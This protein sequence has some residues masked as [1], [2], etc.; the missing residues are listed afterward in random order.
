MLESLKILVAIA[1]FLVALRHFRKSQV[2]LAM[3]FLFFLLFVRMLLAAFHSI[4]FSPV[5]G[6][7]SLIS[8]SS[9]LSVGLCFLV[10]PL[11]KPANKSLY[12]LPRAF[13]FIYAF[14]AL[15]FFS[16]ALNGELKA[17]LPSLLKWVYLLQLIMLFG[18]VLEL[19]GLKKTVQTLLIIYAFPA[20]MLLFSIFLGVS[21]RSELDG[22]T[23]F[24]GG[25][26]HEAVYSTL[27]LTAAFY[28]LVYA[29]VYANRRN[30]SV[31]VIGVIGFFAF[32][33]INYRT[34]MIAFLVMMMALCFGLIKQAK[35]LPRSF[36]TILI[37]LGALGLSVID[38]S[39]LDLGEARERFADLPSVVSN[40]AE[41]MTYPENYSRDERRLFSGRL[42]IW[43]DYVSQANEG[44]VPQILVGRGM[45]SWKD[46]FEKY[47][48]STFVSFYFEL[49]LIG[50]LTFL[51]ILTVLYRRLS[52]MVSVD[53]RT[54]S[55][56]FFVAFI[57][58]NMGTMPMWS[59][60]GLYAFAFLIAC[61]YVYRPEMKVRRQ[62]PITRPNNICSVG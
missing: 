21:K 17:G 60:E 5:V 28:A 20:L 45:E 43:S 16:T 4:T 24:V 15:M 46:Y 29:C 58:L 57:V 30:L 35:P 18:Y 47:A 38:V 1:V 40:A 55:I 6:T 49:G 9:I 7:L 51:V 22:S 42:Y 41:L 8:V 31:V 61:A 11:V 62:I 52:R 34:T 3:Q 12:V 19:D 14:I 48:H 10:L 25:F 39:N 23:S 33:M 56:A 32:S 26:F 36:F 37:L 13:V 53:L 50:L 27:I 54:V 59:I 44:N 2:S